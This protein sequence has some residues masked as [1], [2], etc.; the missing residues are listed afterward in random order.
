MIALLIIA[1]LIYLAFGPW[2]LAATALILGA[3]W[4]AGSLYSALGD[5]LLYLSRH[6]R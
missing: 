4:A 1:A 5:A 2:G 3:I 6:D